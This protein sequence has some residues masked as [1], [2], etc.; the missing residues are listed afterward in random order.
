[1]INVKLEMCQLC[2]I[3]IMGGA[4]RIKKTKRLR[5]DESIHKLF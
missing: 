1:M 2:P 3:Y 4:E 5:Y